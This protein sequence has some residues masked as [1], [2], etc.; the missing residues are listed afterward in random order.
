MAPRAVQPQAVPIETVIDMDEE[1]F[2][3]LSASEREV[4]EEKMN[5]AGVV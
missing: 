2:Q 3:T 5:D 1:N 4:G